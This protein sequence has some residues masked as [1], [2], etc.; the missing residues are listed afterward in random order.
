MMIH[1]QG[2]PS[3]PKLEVTVASIRE[4]CKPFLALSDTERAAKE[5]ER[6][7]RR[8]TACLPVTTVSSPSSSQ[9]PAMSMLATNACHAVSEHRRALPH[10]PCCRCATNLFEFATKMDRHLSA[11]EV[12]HDARVAALK[13][14]LALARTV[15]VEW[16]SVFGQTEMTPRLVALELADLRR[17]VKEMNQLQDVAQRRE[18]QH[19]HLI[20][21]L[22][23]QLRQQN[24]KNWILC[25]CVSTHVVFQQEPP[26][27]LYKKPNLERH[28]MAQA[29][30]SWVPTNFQEI[31]LRKKDCR[32][33]LLRQPHIK[34]IFPTHQ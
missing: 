21:S 18:V 8:A 32:L 11:L 27:S 31:E 12:Q 34:F 16:D 9:R 1:G 28:P 3:V 30:R 5:T 7:V 10:E 13:R 24:Q 29:W 26:S 20:D 19:K 25:C 15:T 4:L 6:I 17:R 22:C 23:L 2:K 14:E 33:L